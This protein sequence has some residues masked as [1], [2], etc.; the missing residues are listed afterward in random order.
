MNGER[1]TSPALAYLRRMAASEHPPAPGAR[2]ARDRRRLTEGPVG[3]TLFHLSWPMTVGLL[4][5]I[6]FNVVDTLYI[7]RLGAD[8]LAAIGFCFPVI[9]ST[10]AV[11]I[12]L[13]TG[14][15]A[16]VSR[17][18][19]AGDME[20]ARRLSTNA[21]ILAVI[22]VGALTAL[23]AASVGPL[24]RNL[25]GAPDELIPLIESYMH[26]WYAGMAFLVVP[27]VGNSILRANGESLL[28]SAMMVVAA[29]LNAVLSPPLI[30]GLLGAPR[31]EMAGAA[32]ATS[33]SR[34]TMLFATLWL[35]QN[36]GRLIDWS[37]ASLSSFAEDARAVFRVGGLAALAQAIQPLSAIAITR[38]LAG[39]GSSAVAGFAVGARIEA[40]FLVPFF[41]LQTGLGPFVGQNA[42][43][44]DA[45][46]VGAA[47]D[48]AMMFIALWAAVAF[49]IL[50][51]FGETV[52]GWFTPDAEI[53]ALSARYVLFAS[54]GF[55]G[56]GLILTGVA[57]LNPLNRPLFALSLTLLRFLGIYL[58]LGFVFSRLQGPEGVFAA[59]GL[60]YLVAGAAAF[61]LT[62][63][64][65]RE[66]KA[67]S[68]AP[69]PGASAAASR[70]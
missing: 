13:G 64:A 48:R 6:A 1:D 43:A 54:G 59:A 23:G 19:G 62:R 29:I 31:L 11:A 67:R 33:L 69:A 44:G 32:I 7:G 58:P 4:S 35:L 40:L 68:S 57:T 46:R 16:L 28:P 25:L 70:P 12:G 14:A 49:A 20:R 53:A 38:L 8:P 3:A 47:R 65:T 36:R 34:S 50:S 39:F 2:P 56:A 60:S 10:S 30:F 55:L 21:L 26:I 9:F 22:I 24:F 52:A 17:A 61:L 15:G 5:V 18:I 42:G 63:W 37:G 45:A 41:A 27:M 51:V 66:L